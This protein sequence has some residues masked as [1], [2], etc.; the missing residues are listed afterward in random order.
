[1]RSST[2]R[3]HI[4]TNAGGEIE[5][6]VACVAVESYRG[7]GVHV[8]RTACFASQIELGDRILQFEWS[9]NVLSS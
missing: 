2:R 7:D 1:M 6:E 3:S 5:I 4:F 9:L 8:S